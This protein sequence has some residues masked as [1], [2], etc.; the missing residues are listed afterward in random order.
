MEYQI[1]DD[2]AEEFGV[3][4]TPAIKE[5]IIGTNIARLYG[6]D[7]DAKLKKIE[8]DEFSQRRKEFLANNPELA[9]A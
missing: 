9:S 3:Q 8:N 4:L 7:V 1:P 2:I 5:K 6:I